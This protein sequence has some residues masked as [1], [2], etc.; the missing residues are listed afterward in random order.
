[1]ADEP[2]AGQFG[3]LQWCVSPREPVQLREVRGV[4]PRAGVPDPS[5]A[6]GLPF[7]VPGPLH[8]SVLR[9]MQY[10]LHRAVGRAL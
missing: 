7:Q 2:T 3:E 8:R 10:S 5:R 4:F 9:H 1:M 6:T